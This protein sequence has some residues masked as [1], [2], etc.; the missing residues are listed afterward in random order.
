VASGCLLAGCAGS[1]L[2]AAVALPTNSPPAVTAPP[3]GAGGRPGQL[4]PDASAP[5]TADTALQLVFANRYDDADRTYS[6][7]VGVDPGNVPARAGYALFLNYRMDFAGARRQAQAAVASG[8]KDA[9][10]YAVLCRVD[11][12]SGDVNG[13]VTA[14]ERAVALDPNDI[15]G[16]LFYSEALADHGQISD[17]RNQLAAAKSLLTPRSTPYEQA[18][19]L[20]EQGNL[21]RDAGDLHGEVDA[22][23]QAVQL[24]PGWVERP[25][26]LAGAYL[27]NNDLKSAHDALQT[28][29]SLAPDDA[30]LLESLG[31][32]SMIESDYVSADD[33]FGKL[34]AL[35]PADAT[36]LTLAAHA[37]MAHT[38]DVDGSVGLL[39]QAL[40]AG[41]GNV[42]AASYLL[43]LERYVR[44][45]DARGRA[46]IAAAVAAYRDDLSPGI[47]SGR[48]VAPDVDGVQ[49]DH[50]RRA[51]AVVN[52]TRA[53][54]GLPAV[55]LD[56]GLNAS[57][58]QHC[59]YWLFNN[60]SD[61][62][63][64]L[65]I[66]QETPGLAGFSG[67][68]AGDRANV[69]GWHSGPITEDIT[70]RGSPE[71]ATAD[72]VNSVYHRFPI[73]R[74]DL[75]AIGYGDCGIGSLPMEDMEFGLAGAGPHHPPTPFP[76][77]GQKN[78]P[79][80]FT[81][82]EIPDPVPTGQPRTTGY[83]V[84]VN[85]DPRVTVSVAAFTLTDASGR[86]VDG[87]KLNPGAPT[88]NCASLLPVT[89]LTA[90]AVYTAHIAGTNTDGPFDI[91]WRF[92]VA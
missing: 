68:R 22:F 36:A 63:R 58:L 66:H 74:A 45:D 37:H 33:A 53:Q 90:G 21:A 29:L 50:Q 67:V 4:P 40:A 19:V 23:K 34:A 7:L 64:N 6:A 73:L 78:V 72:W 59:S 31:N 16:H 12:W 1:S 52:S 44:G 20:R 47:H 77:D 17:A 10:G 91:T 43:A 75:T 51:L 5:P 13:A 35:R 42:V 25:S 39:E 69:H 85:F 30:G 60:G 32:I 41:P 55:V 80:I 56:P 48:A 62:V 71:L 65:G 57:A 92:T 3:F 84:T 2:A 46:E 18:E 24:Q 14:G 27:D 83:P 11:D 81:D 28:A 82:N 86:P 87:Y 76:A 89:P 70:H 9:R 79:A 49:A 8:P 26:E 38:A 88:E 54:A 61:T 15:L